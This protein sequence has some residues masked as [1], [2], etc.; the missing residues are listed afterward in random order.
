MEKTILSTADVARLF[1]VTETTVKRWADEGVLRCQKTPGGHRKFE[2]RSL[3]EF[4]E[5]N[6]FEPVAAL[7]LPG[8]DERTEVIRVAILRKD[9]PR[10]VEGF[11]YKAL[12]ADRNDLFQYFFYLYEHKIALWEIYDLIVRPGMAEIGA[13]WERG[14]IDISHE[15]RASHETIDALTRLQ[16]HIYV[17]PTTGKIA[18]FACLDSEL[19]EIGLRTA[20][21]LFESEG[22]CAHNLGARTPY[23]SVRLAV[24]E[25]H[26]DVLCLSITRIENAA[27]VSRELS[28]LASVVHGYGGRLIV[29]GIAAS[30]AEID[31]SSVD[32]TLSSARDLLEFIGG[33]SRRDRPGAASSL[34]RKP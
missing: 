30:S 22:W 19:H 29:G 9:F 21:N 6:N 16:S 32:A 10:L 8:I 11:V 3:V 7:E 20:A 23:E 17:K 26:P 31:W 25:V 14:E 1:Q 18:L 27:D 12:S 4:A 24:E 15:H 2:I 34:K 28:E 33:E 13:R 5:K